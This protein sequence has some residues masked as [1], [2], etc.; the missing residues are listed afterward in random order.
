MLLLSAV[1]IP[2][3]KQKVELIYNPLSNAVVGK[4]FG[5]D[6]VYGHSL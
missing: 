5:K 6:F 1:L 4:F 2:F 3:F